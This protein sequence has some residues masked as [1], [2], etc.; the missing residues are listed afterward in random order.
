MENFITHWN[1]K[2]VIFVPPL[3]NPTQGTWFL[4]DKNASCL[5][6]NKKF[7]DFIIW[8]FLLVECQN[9]HWESQAS[10]PDTPLICP[11]KI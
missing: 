4:I 3:N 6:R 7:I 1:V 11:D 2:A 5:K 10:N 9:N 8:S